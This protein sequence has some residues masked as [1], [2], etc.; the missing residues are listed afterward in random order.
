MNEALL[1]LL[2]QNR[3]EKIRGNAVIWPNHQM[4]RTAMKKKMMVLPTKFA[5]SQA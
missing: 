3:A 1:N 5:R 2:Q 4:M